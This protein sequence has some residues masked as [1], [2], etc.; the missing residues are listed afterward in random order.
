ML[1]KC[2]SNLFATSS[3]NFLSPLTPRRFFLSSELQRC[4]W[5]PTLNHICPL[6][7]PVLPQSRLEPWSTPLLTGRCLQRGLDGSG[8]LSR[9]HVWLGLG[10]KGQIQDFSLAK[11]HGYTAP[12]GPLMRGSQN[13]SPRSFIPLGL[14]FPPS[15]AWALGMQQ[16]Q[17]ADIYLLSFD[18]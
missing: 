13:S 4:S 10:T 6:Y 17:G 8:I 9:L 15:P 3:R 12:I 2:V 16:A 7:A 11:N 14:L 1:N 5:S 18:C